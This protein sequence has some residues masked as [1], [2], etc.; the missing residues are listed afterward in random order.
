[1]ALLLSRGTQIPEFGL[2]D[3]FTALK[4]VFLNLW[5]NRCRTQEA[6]ERVAVLSL[7]GHTSGALEF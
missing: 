7:R 3:G 2:S 4:R 1:M 6:V 5:A